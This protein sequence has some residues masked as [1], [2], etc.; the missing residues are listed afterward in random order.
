MTRKKGELCDDYGYFY[1]LYSKI[2]R[3]LKSKIK[4]K[5]NQI[6]LSHRNKKRRIYNT[7]KAKPLHCTKPANREHSNS[8]DK[9]E[10][11]TTLVLRSAFCSL[12]YFWCRSLLFFVAIVAGLLSVIVLSFNQSTSSGVS[13]S[14]PL[15]PFATRT[16][17][18]NNNDNGITFLSKNDSRQP[19]SIAFCFLS[20][21]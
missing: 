20:S 2:N 4:I 5:I 7:C 12:V 6:I 1:L 18:G 14:L 9:I 8:N 16:T 17:A 15:P 11:M 3:Q 19:A 13:S 10:T 21:N